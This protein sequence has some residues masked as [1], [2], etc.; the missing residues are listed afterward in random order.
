MEL[1]T[2]VCIG[3]SEKL[4]LN[5]VKAMKDVLVVDGDWDDLYGPYGVICRLA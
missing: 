2:L 3:D 5:L 4:A 1:L